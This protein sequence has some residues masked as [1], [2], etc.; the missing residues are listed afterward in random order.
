MVFHP[1]CLS[2]RDPRAA[3]LAYRDRRNQTAESTTDNNDPDALNRCPSNISENATLGN[4][5][6][7]HANQG[8]IPSIPESMSNAAFEKMGASPSIV[9]KFLSIKQAVLEIQEEMDT[10]G[11]IHLF[12]S[13]R[14]PA[15]PSVMKTSTF[16][17]WS[18]N[19]ST[20][21]FLLLGK[22]RVLQHRR[23]EMHFLLL[24]KLLTNDLLIMVAGACCKRVLRLS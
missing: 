4:D 16:F 8:C 15:T 3:I 22:D 20:P 2:D 21:P 12:L 13:C 7:S 23:F 24:T 1:S 9:R 11:Q 10:L 19:C 18:R 14:D 6:D 17:Q 5:G